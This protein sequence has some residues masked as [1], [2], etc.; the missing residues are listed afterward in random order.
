MNSM[1]MQCSP[2]IETSCSWPSS[3]TTP[4]ATPCLPSPCPCPSC[5]HSIGP[6]GPTGATG[7]SL[8]PTGPA[9]IL[10]AVLN[11]FIFPLTSN[12]STTIP[13]NLVRASN[14]AGAVQFEP[15]M[16][17]FTVILPGRYRIIYCVTFQATGAS[18]GD[19]LV[20][21]VKQNIFPL[22]TATYT[23]P[24][25]PT[26]QSTLNLNGFWTGT[27][28]IGDKIT[29]S[30]LWTSAVANSC[31]LVGSKINGVGAFPTL[32]SLQSLF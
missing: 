28:D 6:T 24:Y 30:A 29:I 27:F 20:L 7:P 12:A 25:S 21:T 26:A 5:P 15:S 10:S 22:S 17:L 3:S 11:V 32:F 1:H 31:N 13:F 16:S 23:L 14:P 4:C 18:A 19:N 9:V 8:L 2:F